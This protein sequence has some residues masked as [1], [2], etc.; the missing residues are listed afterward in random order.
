MSTIQKVRVVT[1]ALI[2]GFFLGELV[3]GVGGV[4]DAN[5]MLVLLALAALA[6]SLGGFP[7]EF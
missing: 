5:A 4:R 7:N 2:A 6:W 3:Y 1:G